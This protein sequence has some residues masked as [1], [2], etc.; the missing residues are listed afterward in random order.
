MTTSQ[1]AYPQEIKFEL[2]KDKIELLERYAENQRVCVSFNI[3]GNEWQGKHYV[4][5]Q[6]WRLQNMG[7]A[8]GG[9]YTPPVVSSSGGQGAS[10][11]DAQPFSSFAASEPPPEAPAAGD[12]G[13]GGGTKDDVPF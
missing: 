12:G 11:F 10:P 13:G 5:L 3:R 2:L 6:A 7:S 9:G 1:D 8:G 4:N